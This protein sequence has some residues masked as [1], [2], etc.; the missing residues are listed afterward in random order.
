V[1]Q[2]TVITTTTV[3]RTEKTVS[4]ETSP[5]MHFI[6]A[7]KNISRFSIRFYFP[8]KMGKILYIPRD[9]KNPYFY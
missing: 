8:S 4:L 2:K 9:A 5:Q 1:T 6:V 7:I 3:L